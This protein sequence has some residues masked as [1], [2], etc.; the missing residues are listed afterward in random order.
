MTVTLGVGLAIAVVL[1]VALTIAADVAGRFG[2]AREHAVAAG[3]AVLQLA[4]VSLIIAA[5][6]QT[7]WGAFAVVLVMGAVAVRTTAKRTG[8]TASWPW[9]ALTMAAGVVPVELVVFL[10]GAVPFTGIAVVALCG[11]VIGNAMTA[12]TLLGRRCFAH[13]RDH[14]GSYE[15][16]LALGFPRGGAVAL[17]LEPVLP[18][19]LVPNLD[20]TRTVGLVTLPGAFIGVLLGGGSPVQAGAAQVLVLLGIMATQA[21]VVLVGS[22]LIGAGRLLPDDL[23]R[24]LHP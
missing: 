10:S 18:E 19:A 2:L 17:V 9:V 21:L 24:A 1:L 3:R 15:A 4:A 22:R 11:I 13:L 14:H 5:A 16:A 12:H 6:V 8:V 23:K 7:L 20:Q